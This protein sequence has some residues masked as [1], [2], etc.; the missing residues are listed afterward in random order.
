MEQ[1][2]SVRHRL[3]VTSQY[4][5]T[6][7]FNLSFQSTNNID[8]VKRPCSSLERLRRYI[9]VISSNYITLHMFKLI[10]INVLLYLGA[11]VGEVDLPRGVGVNLDLGEI[12]F[13]GWKRVIQ[14][15]A[16]GYWERGGDVEE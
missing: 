12:E 1:F 5:K 8:C 16:D 3:L 2:T 10:I 15:V 6:C 11:V 13:S 9:A 7:L 14:G 4:L